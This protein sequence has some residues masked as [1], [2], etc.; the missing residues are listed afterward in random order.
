MDL[1]HDKRFTSRMYRISIYL[2][3]CKANF[4]LHD[5]LRYSTEKLPPHMKH[6]HSFSL[7]PFDFQGAREV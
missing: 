4:T 6:D 7:D 5:V 2:V 1:D 3:I